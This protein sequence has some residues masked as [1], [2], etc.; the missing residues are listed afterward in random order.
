MKWMPTLAAYGSFSE[1]AMRPTYTFFDFSKTWYP[2]GLVGIKMSIPVWDGGQTYFKKQQARLNVVKSENSISYIENAIDM[3]IQNSLIVFKN[4][5]QSLSS[6]KANM[7]LAEEVFTVSKVK[8]EQGLGSVLEVINGESSLKESNVNYYNAMYRQNR[9]RK[10]YR[11]N[12]IRK[13][14]MKTISTQMKT[15]SVL[16]IASAVLVG[17]GEK[18]KSAQLADLKKEYAALSSQ[19]KELEMQIAK[20]D[21]TSLEAQGKMVVAETLVPRSFR[22]YVEVQGR[23]DADQS[24][25]VTARSMGVVS[26]V[27]VVAGQEVKKGQ[28]LAELDNKLG[29]QGIEELKTQLELATTMYD[30]QKALW[31]Q[32]IG[33]EMQ[34]IS[35]RTNKEALEKRLATTREQLDMMRIESPIDGVVDAVNVKVGQAAAPGAPAFQVVNLSL[36]KVKGEVPEKYAANVKTGSEVLLLFPDLKKEVLAKATYSAKVINPMSRTF[37]VEVALTDA[38]ED[39]HPNMITVLKIVDYK[40]DSAIVVPTDVVQQG[41]AG[42]FVFVAQKSG[43]L[44]TVKKK[45]VEVGGSYNGATQILKGLT[46]GEIIITKGYQNVNDGDAIQH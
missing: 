3:E 20:E 26:R 9:L 16:L 38:N 40:V 5:V 24:V 11:F 10:S 21:T 39:Y 46:A 15:L 14:T 35:A 12:K 36:L 45:A 7:K 41:E 32:K 8:Y 19:I 6:Q 28:T 37:T 25:S 4:A 33:S 17:C 30:K 44:T 31:D 1:N 29:L 27:N 34:F 18:D 2:T 23:I 13:Y 43:A 42:N 22:H